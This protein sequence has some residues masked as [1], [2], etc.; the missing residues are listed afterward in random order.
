MEL[1]RDVTEPMVECASCAG[2]FP[3]DQLDEVKRHTPAGKWFY[4]RQCAQC[5]VSEATE[6]ALD[7][8]A[9]TTLAS[10][11][12]SLSQRCTGMSRDDL[13][14]VLQGMSLRLVA[15]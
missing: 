11:L 8:Q 10:E 13:Y 15:A 5:A 4:E 14:E 12:Q 7:Q 9:A 3:S 1:L 2:D 6:K